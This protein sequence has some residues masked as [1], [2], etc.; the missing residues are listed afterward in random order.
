MSTLV[1]KPASVCDNWQWVTMEIFELGVP[2]LKL[3]FN[4][5]SLFKRHSTTLQQTLTRS[6]QNLWVILAILRWT[7]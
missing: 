7:S 1:A 5:N 6:L 2:L 4:T 3:F